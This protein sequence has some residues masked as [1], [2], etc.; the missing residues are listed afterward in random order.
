MDPW[1]IGESH[2]DL[3][4]HNSSV[5]KVWPPSKKHWPYSRAMTASVSGGDIKI[6][7]DAFFFASMVKGRVL[8]RLPGNVLSFVMIFLFRPDREKRLIPALKYCLFKPLGRI[9]YTKKLPQARI[10][11]LLACSSVKVA[12]ESIIVDDSSEIGE[13]EVE[14]GSDSGT[15]CSDDD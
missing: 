10:N 6:L 7:G 2:F 1:A 11:A 3:G 14:K 4:W 9:R 15:T 13:V 8:T 5:S 12:P